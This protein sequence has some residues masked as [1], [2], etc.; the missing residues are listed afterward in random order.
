M[1]LEKI[2]AGI[3]TKAGNG[4]GVADALVL[5]NDC[6]ARTTDLDAH[7]SECPLSAAASTGRRNTLVFMERWSVNHGLSQQTFFYR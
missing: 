6:I 3:R 5:L 1:G 4:L 2:F 7:C